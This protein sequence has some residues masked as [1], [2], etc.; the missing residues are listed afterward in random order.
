LSKHPQA[1]EKI[2]AG[3]KYFTVEKAKG[4]TQ[5]FYITCIDGSRK[6]KLLFSL[7]L[8]LLQMS[9]CV[10]VELAMHDKG[11][12]VYYPRFGADLTE[13]LIC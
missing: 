11:E 4:G 13:P 3:V 9:G 2:G 7:L 6:L 5:Y 12:H 8:S 1:A 10:F